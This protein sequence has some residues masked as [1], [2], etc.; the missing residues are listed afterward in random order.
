MPKF[1]VVPLPETSDL[2]AEKKLLIEEPTEGD[3]RLALV[4]VE[5][6]AVAPDGDGFGAYELYVREK[7]DERLEGE[8]VDGI[9]AGIVDARI[10]ASGLEP[11]A[12]QRLTAVRRTRSI[13]VT[14]EGEQETN[15]VLNTLLPGAFM[16][17]LLMSVL[18][19]GQNMMTNTI[20]EKSSRVVEV[21]L[22]AVSPMELMTGK[23]FGQMLV[24]FVVLALYAAMGIA[25]LVSFAALG[26][27]DPMLLIYQLIFYL[28]AYCY[29][30]SMMGS[31]GA[32][33]NE[34]RE[35]QALMT[36]VMLVI[37]IPWLLW[38]PITRDPNSNFAP[39]TSFVPPINSFVMLL[40]IIST[41]PPPTWQIWLSITIGA[42]GVYFALRIAAKIFRIGL[43]MHGKPPNL[44]T[45]LRWV[46]QA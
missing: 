15:K 35:A 1:E 28:I 14:A 11:E 31:I 36:P 13:T 30:A 24:G 40:R 18:T 33:V 22:S 3:G 17:L 8:I 6:N 34:L 43:L 45:L 7:L 42:V 16:V 19:S 25:A 12:V 32:A 2:E 26:L 39:V 5:P 44:A 46:R 23:I 27:L 41:A 21:L 9:R 29:I 4:V 37:M 10:L 20:E 38:L